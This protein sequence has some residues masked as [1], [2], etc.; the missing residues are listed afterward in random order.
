MQ[1]FVSSLLLN[2]VLL[3]GAVLVM[4]MTPNALAPQKKKNIPIKKV[5]GDLGV[6]RVCVS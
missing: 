6:A 2:G 1:S 3:G 4:M 5:D